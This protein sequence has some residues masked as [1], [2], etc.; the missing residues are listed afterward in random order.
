M[1]KSC[2]FT[3]QIREIQALSLAEIHSLYISA[4]YPH[5][6]VTQD[7]YVVNNVSLV[8]KMKLQKDLVW[9]YNVGHENVCCILKAELN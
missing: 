2:N 3:L 1:K 5:V 7:S 4:L 6:S 9:K 8:Y